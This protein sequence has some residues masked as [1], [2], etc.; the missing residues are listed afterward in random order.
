[1][2]IVTESDDALQHGSIINFVIVDGQVRFEVS[3]DAARRRNIHLSSRLLSVAHTV[4]G[5]LP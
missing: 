3:L 2:L 1:M 4:V 5:A